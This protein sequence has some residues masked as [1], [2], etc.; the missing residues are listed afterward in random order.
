M[1]VEVC[2]LVGAKRRGRGDPAVVGYKAEEA[3]CGHRRKPQS[4]HPGTL[5]Q[6]TVGDRLY[7]PLSAALTEEVLTVPAPSVFPWS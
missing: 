3:G 5:I 2:T 6:I 7:T 1:R 4:N